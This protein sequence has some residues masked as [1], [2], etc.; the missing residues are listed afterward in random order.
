MEVE[1]KLR[2]DKKKEINNLYES[3]GADKPFKDDEKKKQS[4]TKRN[5]DMNDAG[6]VEFKYSTSD[7]GQMT[8]DEFI[9]MLEN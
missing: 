6:E 7:I 3:Y 4:K 8:D 2:E 9:A 5:R 1:R